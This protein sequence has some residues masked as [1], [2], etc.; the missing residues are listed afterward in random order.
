MCRL[1]KS[2]DVNIWKIKDVPTYYFVTDEMLRNLCPP[3][4]HPIVRM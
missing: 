4:K 3:G 2:T 1:D